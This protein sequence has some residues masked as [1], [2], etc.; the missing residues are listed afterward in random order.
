MGDEFKVSFGRSC[1]RS[2]HHN[3]GVI[4]QKDMRS[5]IVEFQFAA[6]LSRACGKI[7][8]HWLRLATTSLA[9]VLR[10]STYCVAQDAVIPSGLVALLADENGSFSNFAG[11]MLER[12]L[13]RSGCKAGDLVKAFYSGDVVSLDGTRMS[14]VSSR[15]PKNGKSCWFDARIAEDRGS[16]L[17][18]DWADGDRK[19]REVRRDWVQ[20]LNG[21]LCSTLREGAAEQL[22]PSEPP[23]GKLQ[24]SSIAGSYTSRQQLG[25]VTVVVSLLVLSLCTWNW[26]LTKKVAAFARTRRSC[27]KEGQ[28]E[29]A[30]RPLMSPLTKGRPKKRHHVGRAEAGGKAGSSDNTSVGTSCSA[31]HQGG[32]HRSSSHCTKNPELL[33][34]SEGKRD[35]RGGVGLIGGKT[36]DIAAA[37]VISAGTSALGALVGSLLGSQVGLAGVC[38]L[39]LVQTA[40][41]VGFASL[42]LIQVDKRIRAERDRENEASGASLLSMLPAA[43]EVDDWEWQCPEGN[44]LEP[45]QAPNLR[46]CDSCGKARAA[47]TNFLYS[48]AS[49]WGACEEC[50][51]IASKQSID[52]PS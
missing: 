32:S 38:T 23:S 44:R 45:W 36:F 15:Q 42:L 10:N 14:C 33:V 41:L 22:S 47:R 5:A 40:V 21:Q 3:N 49:D 35:D 17:L 19:N 13:G 31:V 43:S 12:S 46:A 16:V 30:Q 37:L 1:M 28:S 51:R 25:I 9:M 27:A 39:V 48:T 8:R 2:A 4:G 20:T 52:C 50:V 6:F 29:K 24:K 26:S 18:L 7:R 11:E 34:S